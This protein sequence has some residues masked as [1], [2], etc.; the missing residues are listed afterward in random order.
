MALSPRIYSWFPTSDLL[1]PL[2]FPEPMDMPQ[3]RLPG[4]V[5]EH[6]LSDCFL[7]VSRISVHF[8]PFLIGTVLAGS[9]GWNVVLGKPCGGGGGRGLAV[10]VLLSGC[11]LWHRMF[12]S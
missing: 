12:Y 6:L 8:F 2:F 3:H 4:D 5:W 1:S 7:S 11:D 10:D 9:C